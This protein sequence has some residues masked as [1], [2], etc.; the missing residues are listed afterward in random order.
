MFIMFS[1][2]FLYFCR[3]QPGYHPASSPQHTRT[4]GRLETFGD[5]GRIY[6]DP[7]PHQGYYR[8]PHQPH[9]RDP[10]G[11]YRDHRD[12]RG[13]S[14]D[15][16][17]DPRGA[18]RADPRGDP[19]ADPRG[20]MA[21]SNEMYMEHAQVAQIQRASQGREKQQSMDSGYPSSL[22]RSR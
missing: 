16:R 5:Y 18:A 14:R 6:P 11:D 21:Y 4:Y 3:N 19:R 15:R 17:G 1:L 8:H 13:D 20:P 10:R 7:T 9:H 22:E 12:V 2:N